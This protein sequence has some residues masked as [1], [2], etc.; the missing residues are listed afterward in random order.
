MTEKQ[1]YITAF[2][3]GYFKNNKLKYGM[4]Y[5]SKLNNAIDKAEKKWK[6]YKKQKL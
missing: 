2:L 1:K 6:K 4:Q 3:E 5:I